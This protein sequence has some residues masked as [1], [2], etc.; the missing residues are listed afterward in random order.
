M[1]IALIRLPI[2]CVHLVIG[3]ITLWEYIMCALLLVIYLQIESM[4]NKK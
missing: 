3:N 2:I 1:L 4:N